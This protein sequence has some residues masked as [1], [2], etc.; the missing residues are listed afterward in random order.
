MHEALDWKGKPCVWNP[1]QGGRCHKS[2]NYIEQ[3]VIAR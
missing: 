3:T 1:K 2:G